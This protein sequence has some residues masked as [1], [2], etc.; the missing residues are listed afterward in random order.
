M[1]ITVTENNSGGQLSAQVGDTIEIHLAEN[2]TTGYRWEL[3]DLDPRLFESEDATSDYR[4]GAVGSGGAALFRIKVVAAGSA[5][6]RLKC[7]RRW[8]GNSGV[9]KRFAVTVN[10]S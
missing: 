1:T 9:L 4:S 6:L 8:E 2:A 10:A 7:W 3:D 5:T